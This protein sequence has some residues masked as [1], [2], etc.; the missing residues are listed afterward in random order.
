MSE[1]PT[2][3]CR[4]CGLPKPAD[5]DHFAAENGRLG[6]QCR[7]CDRAI[8]REYRA[9]KRAA[10]AA[11]IAAGDREAVSAWVRRYHASV[12][13]VTVPVLAEYAPELVEER[14]RIG[15]AVASRVRAERVERGLLGNGTVRR[16]DRADAAAKVA[17]VEAKL[18]KETDQRRRKLLRSQLRYWKNPGVRDRALDRSKAKY[19]AKKG[20]AGGR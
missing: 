9:A 16:R 13:V 7:E 4:T 10:L 20:E 12:S 6:G 3:T 11:L 5:H 8:G 18:A 19:R 14:R 15:R 17:E 1:K 2:I